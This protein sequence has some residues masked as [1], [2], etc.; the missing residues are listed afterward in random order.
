MQEG[1]REDQF[2]WNYLGYLYIFDRHHPATD[3][4]D[5]FQDQEDKPAALS[6]IKDNLPNFLGGL[7][8]LG[9]LD[10][11]QVMKR[12][13]GPVRIS[14]TLALQGIP[15]GMTGPELEDSHHA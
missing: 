11:K 7:D 13:G 12:V 15:S 4:A 8:P 9:A 6:S 10:P 14:D 5:T 1:F 3:S 2:N